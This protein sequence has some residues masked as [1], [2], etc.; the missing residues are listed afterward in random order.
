[1][2]L[3]R[4]RIS[5]ELVPTEFSLGQNYP[6]PFNDKTIIKYCIAYKSEVTLKVFDS[7]KKLIEILVNEEKEAGTYEIEFNS[8]SGE[9]R[10]LPAGVYFYELKA[11]EFISTKKMILIK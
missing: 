10:N 9:V 4:N 2:N 3:I 6:N 11:G 7:E 5:E 1:M 8:H